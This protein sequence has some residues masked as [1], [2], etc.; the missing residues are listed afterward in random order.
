[1]RVRLAYGRT[2][3]DVDLPEGRTDLVSPRHAPALDDP[4]AAVASALDAPPG[5]PPLR[6]LG[7]PGHRLAA[8][9]C[10][11]TRPQPRQEVLTALLDRL[12]RI[13]APEDVTVLVATGTHRGHTED[14]LRSEPKWSSGVSSST[15]MLGTRTPWRGGR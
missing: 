10:N 5:C 8:S 4:A 2:G 1:M 15:T 13:I 12:D 11:G 3:L 6:E 14:E 7:R 9:V